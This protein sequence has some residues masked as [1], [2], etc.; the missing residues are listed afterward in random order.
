MEPS[1]IKACYQFLPI[2]N[3][4]SEFLS[5]VGAHLNSAFLS[6]LANEVFFGLSHEM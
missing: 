6:D 1:L 2:E 3:S 4:Q 5:D